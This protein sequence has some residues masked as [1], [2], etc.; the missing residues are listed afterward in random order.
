MVGALALAVALQRVEL[1][2]VSD[3]ELARLE[4]STV[5]ATWGP[6]GL[7]RAAEVVYC[8]LS[9]GYRTSPVMQT[10]YDRR[11]SLARVARVPGV[12]QVLLPA[13]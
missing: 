7:G 3:I 13:I 10:K 5:R 6:T 12:A 11:A 2:D 8:L 4:T 9:P 1:A